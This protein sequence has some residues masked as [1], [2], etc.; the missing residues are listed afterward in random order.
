MYYPPTLLGLSCNA[1]I[2]LEILSK[3]EHFTAILA[4]ELLSQSL[5]LIPFCE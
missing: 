4:M 2:T 1:L 5:E 3:M